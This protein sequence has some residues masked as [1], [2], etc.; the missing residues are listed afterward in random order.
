MLQPVSLI[1]LFNI[2]V[3]VK[4]VVKFHLQSRFTFGCKS[5]GVARLSAA[6]GRP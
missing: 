2:S 3:D 4:V 6:R 1:F 5:S